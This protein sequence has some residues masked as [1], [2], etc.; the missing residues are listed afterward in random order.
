MLRCGS[1]GIAISYRH[2]DVVDL[3]STLLRGGATAAGIRRKL[4]AL[5]VPEPM[6]NE[7]QAKIER[8]TGLI[9]SAPPAVAKDERTLCS[10]W[11]DGPQAGDNTWPGVRSR[12]L[13]DLP[14]EAVASIDR[15]SSKIVSLLCPPGLSEFRS[16]GLV[17]GYVQS[18]K[19]T[20][21]ASVIGKAA[22]A[23]YRMIVVLSGMH[24]SLRRQTQERLDGFLRQSNES[25]WW[26]FSDENED[27]INPSDRNINLLLNDKDKRFLTVI[28]KNVTRLADFITFLES[29]D[30]RIVEDLP[31]LVIDDEA[32]QASIDTSPAED[33]RKRSRINSLI[34]RLLDHK[35][36]AYV[37]YTATPFA[38][39]LIDPDVPEDLY[40]RDFIVDLPK[41]E[42]YFGP[43]QLYGRER[44]AVDEEEWQSEGLNMVRYVPDED[45]AALR[46]PR[47]RK[48][49][50]S[51]EPV[52]PDSLERSLRYFVMATAARRVRDGE[53][54][55]STML[56]HT[57]V[58]SD[59]QER[60]KE[61][62]VSE[63][64]QLRRRVQAEDDGLIDELADQWSDET[65]RLP[66][67]TL[68]LESVDFRSLMSELPGVLMDVE[69]KVD[70]Y[71]SDDRLQYGDDPAT[72]V[73][74]G[75][76]TLSRGLTLQ[77]LVVSYF[78]RAAS[79]YDTLLQMGRWFG[80]REGYED[81]P[82]LWTTRELEEQFMMLATVE[83]E[84]REDIKRYERERITPTDFPVH[85]RTHPKLAITSAMKMQAAV[86]AKVSYS[87][88]RIQTILFN[89]RDK[90]WLKT[91][92]D[93][94][95][96][97]VGQLGFAP[98]G[99]GAAF[100]SRRVSAD[101][102]VEFLTRY[103]FHQNAYD[104]R[105]EPLIGYIESQRD[106][107]ELEY[108]NVAI[109]SQTSNRIGQIDLGLDAPVNLITR[110][111]TNQDTYANIK[112]L[113]SRPD[114]VVDIDVGTDVRAATWDV[115]V[116]HRPEGVGLLLLYP[117]GADSRTASA[118]KGRRSRYDLEAV[119]DVIG[120]SLVF[121]EASR[122]ETAQTY[123]TAPISPDYEPEH[124]EIELEE[125]S[126]NAA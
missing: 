100:V 58:F 49:R 6:L 85:I 62:V 97:L 4:G 95:K 84:I 70:N 115:Q 46:P 23:G 13:E 71:K 89:H 68:G 31:F 106:V 88:R 52:V 61:P 34:V 35:K 104:L 44:L 59:I 120:V 2:E 10:Q 123:V 93:A 77:G 21:F 80:Y 56:V 29:A 101:L 42:G 67:I 33:Q 118:A 109:V 74:I 86:E 7:A 90:E 16:R 64:L 30:P 75:G 15:A 92:L 112:T 43:E 37:G 79:A 36:V 18:G 126:D 32:D 78:I 110:T 24:N 113:M 14:E 3:Y 48:K 51:F 8:A 54:R 27:F 40:P 66:A 65:E 121:P 69:V 108:W 20:N 94:A 5:G 102:I 63:L 91:N 119:E 45:V 76:N 38:N 25:I 19:T 73:A 99:S 55:H 122:D 81:L 82:R 47:G 9:R 41:P 125:T 105:T 83:A 87:G 117:I 107:G 114:S 1:E 50:E 17:L 28:K 26:M 12:L 57:T 72:T 11:Y 124:E 53:K 98:V 96:A 60:M 22:D 111:K 103:N 116:Q 39:L